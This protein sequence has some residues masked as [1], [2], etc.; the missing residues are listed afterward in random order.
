M[1]NLNDLSRPL[2]VDIGC[3]FGSSLIGLASLDAQ[4]GCASSDVV[5][6]A[7]CNF[8]GGDLSQLATRFGHGIATRW[9]LQGRLQF[10][11]ISAKSLLDQ[12]AQYY[13]GRVALI[14]I[15]FPSP[16]C[17][18][19]EG[20]AQLPGGPLSSLEF[21]VNEALMAKVSQIL[22]SSHGYM[23]VQSNCE[24]VALRIQETGAK[25]GLESTPASNPVFIGCDLTQ[26][27]SRWMEQGGNK[28]AIGQYW[29][30]VPLLPPGCQTETSVLPIDQH[31]RSSMFDAC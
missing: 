11:D 1:E 5:A 22:K 17:L 3:G 24:D 2:V 13:P 8:V 9:G 7:D 14:L 30:S 12:I 23:L 21:M 31:S 27:T 16:Y 15:Q 19:E 18:H 6:F 26:R 4:S 25:Y 20:N 10:N 28:R 29:S